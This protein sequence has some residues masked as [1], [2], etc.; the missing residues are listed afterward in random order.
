[1]NSYIEYVFKNLKTDDKTYNLNLSKKL[2]YLAV[3]LMKR[4]FMKNNYVGEKMIIYSYSE[5]LKKGA[6]YLRLDS[7]QVIKEI[8]K[9][10][11]LEKLSF[12]EMLGIYY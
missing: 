10:S 5:L 11:D 4:I 8:L 6:N 12:D 3:D 9:S 1:M 7:I 2:K